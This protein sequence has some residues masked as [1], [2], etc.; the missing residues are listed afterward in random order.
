MTLQV[1]TTQHSTAELALMAEHLE[2]GTLR[3]T[4]TAE[5]LA[6]RGL[7]EAWAPAL[8]ALRE[9]GYTEA[10]LAQSLRAVL[11]ARALGPRIDV[12]ST[13]PQGAEGLLTGTAHSLRTLLTHARRSVLLAGYRITDRH[14]LDPLVRHPDAQVQLDLF[15]DIPEDE[16]D[17]SLAPH[18]RAVV[19]YRRWAELHCPLGL[20][21]PR[22][23]YAPCQVSPEAEAPFRKMHMKTVLIDEATWFVSSANFSWHGQHQNFELGARVDDPT[24]CR[25]VRQHFEQMCEAGV[26]RKLDLS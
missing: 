18:D 12:V 11:D 21:P 1:L 2:A 22:A 25:R 4:H 26:F 6:L 23:W 20:P 16:C 5:R 7:P 8:V 3:L 13:Q 9:A 19:W 17:R 15:L 24:A 10:V 14:L